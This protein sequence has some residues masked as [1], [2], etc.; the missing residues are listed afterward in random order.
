MDW[1]LVAGIVTILGGLMASVG[2]IALGVVSPVVG[3][4]AGINP[5]LQAIRVQRT[6]L[7]RRWFGVAAI[8]GFILAIVGGLWLNI[9]SE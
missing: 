1:S 3:Y 9:V 4:S 6:G 8:V 7:R 5:D 2:M